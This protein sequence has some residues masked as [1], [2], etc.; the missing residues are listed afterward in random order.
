MARESTVCTMHSAYTFILI[1]VGPF[2]EIGVVAGGYIG[3]EAQLYE[4]AKQ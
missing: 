4:V 3:I 1:V 2:D